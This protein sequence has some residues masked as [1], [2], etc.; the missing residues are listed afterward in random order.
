MAETFSHE[1]KA[2]CKLEHSRSPNPLSPTQPNPTYSPQPKPRF[3]GVRVISSEILKNFFWVSARKSPLWLFF[4]SVAAPRNCSF[5]CYSS[6]NLQYILGAFIFKVR[7]LS[8]TDSST[9]AIRNLYAIFKRQPPK[10]NH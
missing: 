7:S 1:H 8:T 2:K 6:P 9:P 4:F 3:S 5:S 10:T